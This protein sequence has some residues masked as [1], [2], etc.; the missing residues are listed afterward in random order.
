MLSLLA[1]GQD[2]P[3]LLVAALIVLAA[4]LVSVW[5]L[6]R[7]RAQRRSYEDQLTA[8]AS[9][10]AVHTERLRIARELHD[11]ASHGLGM[12]TVRAAT[13]TLTSDEDDRERR[14]ALI[15]IERL[16]R[17]A[18]TELRHMLTL[19]RG[20]GESPAPLRPTDSLADLPRIIEEARRAGLD[21]TLRQ[22]D[23]GH[24]APGVQLTICATIREALANV[25]KHAGPTTADVAIERV[26]NA[27]TVDVRDAGPSR[28][29]APH[30]G[31][32]NG[33]RG[34]RERL[35]VHHGNLTTGP[36]EGGYRLLAY[37]PERT[38]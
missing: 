31:T 4:V 32:G 12:M 38:E 22:E 21:I 34:L 3:Y 15:D 19:L 10:K 6:V 30:P 20:N 25:L 24:L 9:D 26:R 27:I 17:E 29:W 1:L 37:L 2:T 5:A 35:A 14:Q 36:V 13:A 11:L 28:E 8:W 7:S 33:L 18:T 23:L 16:G